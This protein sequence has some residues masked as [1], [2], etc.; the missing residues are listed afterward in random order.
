MVRRH[1]YENMMRPS[2]TPHSPLLS[3]SLQHQQPLSPIPPAPASPSPLQQQN[4]AAGRERVHTVSVARMSVGSMQTNGSPVKHGMRSRASTGSV[5]LSAS[6]KRGYENVVVLTAT[7]P[8][9]E[10][11]SSQIVPLQSTPQPPL[12]W[13]SSE[14]LSPSPPLPDRNYLDS[15]ILTPPPDLASPPPGAGGSRKAS[16][17][18][19]QQPPPLH[20]V[21]ATGNE[22][23]IVNPKHL[24]KK[25]EER[26]REEQEVGVAEGQEGV[27][28]VPSLPLRA[29]QRMSSREDLLAEVGGEVSPQPPD[30]SRTAVNYAVLGMKNDHTP[31]VPPSDAGSNDPIAYSVVKL[32]PVRGQGEVSEDILPL[33]TSPQP[34]EVASPTPTPTP[35]SAGSTQFSPTP[36]KM[37][38]HY[39]EIEGGSQVSGW[40]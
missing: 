35:T 15:D 21:S 17:A 24:L 23:A 28:L 34:Y 26:E 8:Q 4:N 22:Y 9:Y 10:H 5:Q 38:P 3:P 18:S 7:V 12:P 29:H 1:T 13:A 16:T 37:D 32:D 33:P 6:N 39:E 19:L 25:H 36:S 2:S 14:P 31:S 40:S 11:I 20:E 27:G 30:G